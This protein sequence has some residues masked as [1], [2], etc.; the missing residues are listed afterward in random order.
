MVR[1]RKIRLFLLLLTCWGTAALAGTQCL[2]GSLIK[3]FFP[4]D[5]AHV[6]ESEIP[7]M[8]SRYDQI[9]ADLLDGLGNLEKPSKVP[10]DMTQTTWGYG[11]DPWGNESN[12]FRGLRERIQF[13]LAPYLDTKI[14]SQQNKEIYYAHE[15][16]HSIFARNIPKFSRQHQEFLKLWSSKFNEKQVSRRIESALKVLKDP[17]YKGPAWLSEKAQKHF[18][19]IPQDKRD[20]MI[21]ALESIQ[22]SRGTGFKNYDLLLGN[23]L[24]HHEFFAD[25]FA[26]T[27]KNNPNEIYDALRT[28]GYVPDERKYGARSFV[29][30]SKEIK[31]FDET[32][33][34]T[35]L[36]VGASEHNV[37][38]PL[39]Q[40]VWENFLS[41]PW[42]QQKRGA[43]LEAILKA[44]ARDL[45][46]N[47]SIVDLTKGRDVRQMN[48]DMAKYLSDEM[49]KIAPPGTTINKPIEYFTGYES[50]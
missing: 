28:P 27:W 46:E 18:Q 29:P 42:A 48:I 8:A 15:L 14:V 30:S 2:E 3:I 25:A 19:S 39:R 11:S 33:G 40:Y 31:N 12:G 22:E 34:D 26:V 38:G 37:F 36:D 9:T 20:R 16:G 13:S 50:N 17:N 49:L 7:G 6:H 5:S 45:D 1:S 44:S 41:Q 10:I 24:P 32:W 21:Q 43:A 4:D 23:M 47:V 35:G